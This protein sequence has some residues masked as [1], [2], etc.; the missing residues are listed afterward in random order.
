M[1]ELR[2]K[3]AKCSLKIFST[4]GTIGI[5]KC[6]AEA[7][8][9]RCGMDSTLILNYNVYVCVDFIHEL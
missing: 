8:S 3:V 6:C 5:Y 7:H 2:I 1:F 9:F 4:V